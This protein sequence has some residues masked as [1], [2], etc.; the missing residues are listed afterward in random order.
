MHGIYSISETLFVTDASA[1]LIKIMTGLSGTVNFLN[2][3]GILYNSFGITCK[4]GTS[5]PF[6][7]GQVSSNVKKVHGYIKSTVR[8]VKERNNLKEDSTTNGPHGTVSQKT[9][10]SV[11]LLKNGVN[12]AIKK[13]LPATNP[14]IL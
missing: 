4:I 10:T 5:Q 3:L 8:K 9:Q 1:G 13:L 2:H 12:N 7:P 6:T 14:K 11:K